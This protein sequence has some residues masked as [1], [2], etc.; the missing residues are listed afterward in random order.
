MVSLGGSPR[1]PEEMG[2]D[3]LSMIGSKVAEIEKEAEKNPAPVEKPKKK[4]NKDVD[5]NA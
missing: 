1:P 3:W 2:E 5:P 4:A